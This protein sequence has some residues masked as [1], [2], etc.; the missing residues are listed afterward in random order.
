MNKPASE[1]LVNLS[2]FILN[3]YQNNLSSFDKSKELSSTAQRM[4]IGMCKMLPG[5]TRATSE[6]TSLKDHVQ[7]CIDVINENK[8]IKEGDSIVLDIT[9]AQY[10][11]FVNGL[12]TLVKNELSS[13]D[14]NQSKPY[15][16]GF[17]F[18]LFSKS[19]NKN[20][21]ETF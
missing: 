7:Y 8:A 9:S 1:K 16:V 11:K 4:V 10:K 14:I 2:S 12:N 21:I 17:V 5:F 20:F 18:Q 13:L 15:S 3:V 6:N 19:M